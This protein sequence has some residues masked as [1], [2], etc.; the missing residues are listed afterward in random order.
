MREWE[1]RWHNQPVRDFLESRQF[2]ARQALLRWLRWKLRRPRCQLLRVVPSIEVRDMK[3]AIEYG[4]PLTN[5][6]NEPRVQW[7]RRIQVRR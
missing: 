5:E 2:I 1:K 4:R 3:S 7:D 6:C